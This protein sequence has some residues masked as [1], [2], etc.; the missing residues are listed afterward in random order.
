ME[1]SETT[2]VSD[3][4]NR[5]PKVLSRTTGSGGNDY[6]GFFGVAVIRFRINELLS[7]CNARRPREQPVHM[8]DLAEAIGVARSTLAGLTTLTREP[9]TNTATL[10]ALCRFFQERLPNFELGMLLDFDPP[11][12]QTHTVHIDELYPLRAARGGRPRQRRQ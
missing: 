3:D 11:L 5:P 6:W 4:T 8:E 2:V 1:L 9:V 12:A 10:E 7:E